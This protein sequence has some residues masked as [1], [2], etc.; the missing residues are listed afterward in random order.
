MEESEEE[1]KLFEEE[2]ANYTGLC[3]LMKEVLKEKVEKC[4][5]S[6]RISDSPCILVT[7]E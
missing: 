7:G 3:D 4:I 2:K 1:K 5:V 6:Q